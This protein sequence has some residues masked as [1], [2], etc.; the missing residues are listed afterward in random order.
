[1]EGEHIIA[2]QAIVIAS[3]C[4]PNKRVIWPVSIT[5]NAEKRQGNIRQVD[6][7]FPTKEDNLP[8]HAVNGEI[9]K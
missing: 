1:M 7:S 3:F 2:E 6:V 4:P 8:I 5:V 9:S